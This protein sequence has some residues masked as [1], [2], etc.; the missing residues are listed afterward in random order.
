[1]VAAT[2]AVHANPATAAMRKGNAVH[3]AHPPVQARLAAIM[4]AEAAAVLAQQAPAFQELASL[5]AQ[6]IGLAHLAHRLGQTAK[7]AQR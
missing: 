5:E 1:M 3:L 7:A 4:A 2:A 6:I